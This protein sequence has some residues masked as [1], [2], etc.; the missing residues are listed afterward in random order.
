MLIAQNERLFLALRALCH[1]DGLMTTFPGQGMIY[2]GAARFHAFWIWDASAPV[3]RDAHGMF[4]STH[5]SFLCQSMRQE[6][7]LSG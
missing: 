7:L 2:A 1:P 5:S 6:I 3:A 4:N